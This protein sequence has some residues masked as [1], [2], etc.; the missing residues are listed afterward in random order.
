M[1]SA[2]LTRQRALIQVALA[3]QHASAGSLR[4]AHERALAAEQQ[5][6]QMIAALFTL[7]RGQTGL[8]RRDDVDLADIAREAVA[9]HGDEAAGL[10]LT[11]R[12]QLDPAPARG[13][14]RL[15]ERLLANL[16][17]N[18]VRHNSVAGQVRSRP[19]RANVPYS[20]TWPTPA[21]WW[22]TRM[23]SA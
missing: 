5:L 22:P 4:E 12:T 18:A 6:E 20:C 2:P 16:V 15:I 17:A 23:S 13:D 9:A 19:E 1:S 10:A 11:V 8:E 14:S 7:T 21:R 3:D